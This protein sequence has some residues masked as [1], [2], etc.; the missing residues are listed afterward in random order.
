MK[1]AGVLLAVVL[2]AAAVVVAAAPAAPP[3]NQAP[4]TISGTPR[5]GETLTAQNG[6][7]TGSPT[8][9]QYQWLRCNAAGASCAN[10]AGAVQKTYLL[11]SVDAGRT[12]RVLVTA[13]NTEGASGVR[14][15]PTAVVTAST[16][17]QNT[18]RPTI[19]G[20]PEVGQQ[21]TAEEG[22][23]TNSPTS[24]GYVWL[25]CDIDGANCSPIELAASKNYDVRAADIGS[26]LRVRVTARNAAGAGSATSAPS[27]FVVPSTPVTQQRPTLRL[28]SARFLGTRLYVRFRICDDDPRNL[29]ILAT[30]SKPRVG[31]QTRRFSTL[32]P[33][34]P[35][36]VYTRKWVPARKFRTK[37][38]YTVTVRVRDTSGLTSLPVR[39][40]FFLR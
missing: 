33:P 17:P 10:I 39:K 1:R 5:V 29:T 35:C 36:G 7:W 9:F 21:L 27:G 2:A 8:T 30:D 34:N 19:S 11:S 23:W 40:T 13:L 3:A 20:E 4:P 15:A 26:R 6:T 22:T 32:I 38:R 37:G 28:I 16:A 12:I 18:G 25:R 14:S 31:T 24:F